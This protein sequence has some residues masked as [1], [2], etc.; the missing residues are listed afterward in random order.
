[1]WYFKHG[2]YFQG[3]MGKLCWVLQY[4]FAF[5]GYG[6]ALKRIC[7][8]PTLEEQKKMYNELLVVRFIK[9][10]PQLLV[11]FLAKITALLLCNRIVLWFGGGVPGKQYELI[12]KD[13]VPIEQYIARTFDGVAEH[14]HLRKANYFYYNCLTGHFLRDNCP[15]YLKE[16]NF[17]RLKA[18]TIDRLSVVT[19]TFM[20]E[21][22]ARKYTKV[23][24][25]VCFSMM[26]GRVGA[27]QL[28]G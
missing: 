5:L 28:G 21:L 16:S 3:G 14:S 9:H 15:S 4:L 7:N 22:K 17:Q 25:G 2:L 13:G 10:G 20:G 23:R 24:K 12:K 18:G 1:M 11:W 27:E 26:T 6:R 8:A 19:G